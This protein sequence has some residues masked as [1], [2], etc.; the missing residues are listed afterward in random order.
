MADLVLNHPL[1]ASAPPGARRTVGALTLVLLTAPVLLLAVPYTGGDATTVDVTPADVG[2]ALLVGFCSVQVLRGRTRPLSPVA[3]LVFAAPT[4][5][6]AVACVTASDPWAALPGLARYLQIFVLIPASVVL[7]VRDQQAF[8]VVAASLVL[9]AAVEGGIG[10]HQYASGTGASYMGQDIRAVGTFGATDV[11]GMATVVALGAVVAVALALKPP[12]PRPAWWLPGLLVTGCLLTVPLVVSFSRGAWIA[13]VLTLLVLI[14]FA[15][16]RRLLQILAG[17]AAALVVLIGG[18][19]VGSAL[20]NE[21]LSSITQVTDS[22][23][24]SVTDRYTMWSAAAGMWQEHPVT[25][26]GLKGFAAHRDAHAG[27]SLS[28]GSDT[29]GAGRDFHRQPLLSPHNMYLLVL[30]EQG[31][32]GV[33]GLVGSWLALLVLALRRTWRATFRGCGQG[34]DCGLVAVGLLVWQLIDFLYADI[35]GPSTALTGIVFGLC[36]W[37]ALAAPEGAGRHG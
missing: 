24:Q 37:W 7:L 20:L 6:L 35:G 31:L 33:V 4:V 26:V 9:L 1:R 10:L 16:L 8:R 23:D 15:G 3:V 19:G 12:V 18:F 17:A 28:A 21:R 25:G 13:T 14:S 32:L 22:P 5:A 34:A 30:S 36:A 11:M 27:L 29:A 2:T